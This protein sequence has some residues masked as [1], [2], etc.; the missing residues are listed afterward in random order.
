[1]VKFLFSLQGTPS[2]CSHYRMFPACF[3]IFPCSTT[4]NF[5]VI[6]FPPVYLRSTIIFIAG[7]EELL[8]KLPLITRNFTG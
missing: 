2:Y 8:L 4:V 6:K 5:P 3:T 7:V 1:M